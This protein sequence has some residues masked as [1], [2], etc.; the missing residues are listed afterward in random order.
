MSRSPYISPNS[1]FDRA[2]GYFDN[3]AADDRDEYLDC[4]KLYLDMDDETYDR[5]LEEN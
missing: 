2:P 5:L 1:L 3:E 4:N